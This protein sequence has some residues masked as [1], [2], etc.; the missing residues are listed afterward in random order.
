VAGS[1]RQWVFDRILGI[2]GYL[3]Y[4]VGG[5]LSLIIPVSIS[6]LVADAIA[7]LNFVLNSR[8]RKA[9]LANL[10][11]V[12]EPSV[13]E[14]EIKKTA[15][16]TFRNFGRF[17]VDF[18]R[19][20]SFSRKSLARLGQGQ[21]VDAIRREL[22]NGNGVI[23]LGAHLGNW[24]LGGAVVAM[25]GLP[26]SAVAMPHRSVL[27]DRFFVRRRMG[28]GINVV[29]SAD[30]TKGLLGALRRNE[31]VAIL[32]DRNVLGKG[33]GRE[34]FGAQALMPYGHVALS[35]RTGAPI[36]PGFVVR[37]RG[38]RSRLVVEEAIRPGKGPGAFEELMQKCVK[39]ME[40][41]LRNYPEEWFAF[42]HIWAED[43][44]H[45]SES[46]VKRGGIV[47][48]DALVVHGPA[49]RRNIGATHT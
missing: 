38:A 11:H 23:L 24:E 14:E 21:V 39:V 13:S 29:S 9:V 26:L 20:P 35:L 2:F 22:R 17:I 44:K 1:T 16:R 4:E 46:H 8:S 47:E 30:A 40:K 3:L 41:Y 32:G 10:R 5:V 34:F 36:V 15:R 42:E 18:L 6:Y 31:C 28:R 25:S 48:D 43:D 19:F 27:I 33:I 12:L 37:E 49:K 7:D 45:L